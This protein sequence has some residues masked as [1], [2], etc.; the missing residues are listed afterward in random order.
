MEPKTLD[1]EMLVLTALPQPRLQ[2][3]WDLLAPPPPLYLEDIRSTW[4]DLRSSAC[5][6][7]GRHMQANPE[8]PKKNN[9]K[10]KKI[11]RKPLT[12]KNK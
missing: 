9:D 12:A 1:P 10:S 4:L 2:D 8:P 5:S 3:M 6:L 7:Y 11:S